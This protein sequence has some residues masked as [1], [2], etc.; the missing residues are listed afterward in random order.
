MMDSV[1]EI[2]FS[3][4]KAQKKIF[5]FAPTFAHCKCIIVKLESF[6]PSVSEH[7]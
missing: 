7:L 2:Q 3:G 4:G 6:G 1:L 5:P